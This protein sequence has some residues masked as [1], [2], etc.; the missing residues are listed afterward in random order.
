M[1]RLVLK[2]PFVGLFLFEQLQKHNITDEHRDTSERWRNERLHFLSLLAKM[3]RTY[4]E[5]YI[6]V[7]IHIFEVHAVSSSVFRISP[8]WH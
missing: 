7:Q 3:L 4:L 6:C 2:I 1:L 8:Q 5:G